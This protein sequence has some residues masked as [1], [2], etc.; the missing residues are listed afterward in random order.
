MVDRRVLINGASQQD[1]F[2]DKQTV[3]PPPPPSPNLVHDLTTLIGGDGDQTSTR[4]KRWLDE[5][6]RNAGNAAATGI[7]GVLSSPTSGIT[8]TQANSGYPDIPAGGNGT[9]ATR[10]QV[11]A[12]NSLGCGGTVQFH[13]AVTTDQGPFSIN[14]TVPEEECP[15]TLSPP[16]PGRL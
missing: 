13:V 6:I 15:T 5:R 7:S 4:V 2:F 14:F 8:I 9:N 16:R 1:V 3:G 12:D 11:S 10:F